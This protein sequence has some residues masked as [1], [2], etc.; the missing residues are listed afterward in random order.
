MPK[1]HKKEAEKYFEATG[2]RKESVARARIVQGSGSFAING[3]RLE[4]YLPTERLRKVVRA[5]LALTDTTEKLNVT[6]LA[7]GGGVTGQAEAARLAL[8]RALVLWSVELKKKL[9]KAGYLTRDARAVERKK[10]GLKK[11]RRAPQWQKR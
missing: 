3:K 5:P 6:V 10:Y 1:T 8:A 7:K 11:A 2:R 9:R 4:A